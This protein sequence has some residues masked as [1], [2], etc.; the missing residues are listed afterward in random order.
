MKK[1][2]ISLLFISFLVNF[3]A[4]Q[5]QLNSQYMFNDFVINPAVAGTK[6]ASNISMSFRR[7]WV[8]IDGS[9]IS[10]TLSGHTYLGK[11]VGIGGMFFNDSYGPTRLSGVGAAISYIF[12]VTKKSKISLGLNPNF[13]QFVIKRDR[14]ITEVS[15]DNTIANSTQY[16]LIP[17]LNC[18]LLWFSEKFNVGI[19]AFNLIESK[20]DLYD[21][22]NPVTGKINRAIYANAGYKFKVS[23]KFAI[24]PSVLYRHMFNAP[25]QVDANLQFIFKDMFWIGFSY[26]TS[27]A[28]TALLGVRVNRLTFGYSYDYTLS[29]LQKYNSG[30]HELFVSLKLRDNKNKS[31]WQKRNRIYSADSS[32][33]N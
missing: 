14:L 2:I 18:G 15:G 17:D 22:S 8:G 26:R 24:M 9:P 10:Q 5:L 25:S 23:E 21:V 4:Q 32:F 1:N 13:S 6:D 28:A 11:G 3:N 16:G 20:K 27:D 12:N 29:A 33:E 31:P 19:T 30:S 7:Q